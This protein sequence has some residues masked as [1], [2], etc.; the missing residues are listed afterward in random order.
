MLHHVS[1][2]AVFHAFFPVY[3]DY[4]AKHGSDS[5]ESAG[6]YSKADA[7]QL[8]CSPSSCQTM[9]S[10]L[11]SFLFTVTTRPRAAWT[12]TSQQAWTTT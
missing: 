5:Y 2:T 1:C 6:L 8:P 4:Q 3:S 12:A 7:H 11:L 9:L 10:V